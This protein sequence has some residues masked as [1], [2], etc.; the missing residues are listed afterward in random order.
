MRRIRV[1]YFISFRFSTKFKILFFLINSTVDESHQKVVQL[2][3]KHGEA[4]ERNPLL[5]VAIFGHGPFVGDYGL[6]LDD[7]TDQSFCI[8]GIPELLKFFDQPSSGL[9]IE[10]WKQ[11]DLKSPHEQPNNNGHRIIIQIYEF[12]T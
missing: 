7:G 9:Q 3:T 11:P 6:E 1:N 2:I 4:T 12:T 5:Y 10:E 8:H